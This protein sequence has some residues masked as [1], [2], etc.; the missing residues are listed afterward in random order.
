M[1]DFPAL[2]LPALASFPTELSSSDALVLNALKRGTS[3]TVSLFAS[4]NTTDLSLGDS[5]TIVSISANAFTDATNTDFV[6]EASSVLGGLNQSVHILSTT[7]SIN[8]TAAGASTV[9]LYTVPA[10]RTA[11]IVGAITRITA[12]TGTV[13]VDAAV[14]V[15]INGTQDDIIASTTLSQL[16]DTNDAYYLTNSSGLFR[17]ADATEV[18][19][20]GKDT[21]STGATV[22][23]VSVDLLGYIL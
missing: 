22:H 17:I 21:S 14:G 6:G 5:S 13:T 11:I 1:T 3:G 8:L 9:D 10:G 15:G 20:L 4:G 16:R 2:G 19:R 23:T 12:V 18:I 7:S